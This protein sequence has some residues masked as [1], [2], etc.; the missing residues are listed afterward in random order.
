MAEE[1]DKSG[2]AQRLRRARLEAGFTRG[3]EAVERFGWN[4]NTYKSNENGA[5][6]FSFDQAKTYAAAFG[7][8]AE[9]LYDG[10][11]SM[12]PGV[13]A[14]PAPAKRRTRQAPLV[15]YVGAGSRTHLFSEGQG[16]LGRVSA[17]DDATEETVAVEIRG[18]SLGA[19]FRGWLVFYDDVRS[20]VTPDLHQ[21]LCIVGLKDGRILIKKL[22][23]SRTDGLFHLLSHTEEPLMDQAVSWAAAVTSMRPQ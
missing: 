15:G 3:A 19:F 16:P 18:D 8:G 2:R 4:R 9:W 5:A 6:P 21:K 10:T 14:K 17:P 22:Q 20:P 7:V 1:P 23:P 12:H 11:G 13:I